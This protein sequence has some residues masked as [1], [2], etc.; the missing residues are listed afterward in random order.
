MVSA[1]C[2]AARSALERRAPGALAA[3]GPV[4]GEALDRFACD[5]LRSLALDTVENA[6]SGHP[7]GPCSSMDMAYLLHRYHL[8]FSSDPRWPDRDRFVLSG[9]HM[10][11]M[12][13]GLLFL[14][15]RL[16]L[17]DLKRFRQLGSPTQ[18]HPVN[19]LC[20]GVETT[21]GPLG[22]GFANG[23]GLALGEWLG[24][25]TFGAELVDHRVWVLATDGDLQEGICREAAQLAGHW[26]LGRLKV[27]F[28]SNRIQLASPTASCWSEDVSAFFRGAGWRVLE[29]DGHDHAALRG[30]LAA[31]AAEEA[32]PSIL[33]AHTRIAQGTKKEGLVETHGAP[34]GAATLEAFKRDQGFPPD[35]FWVPEAVARSL[36]GTRTRGD[37]IQ[38]A[39]RN[40]LAGK[41]SHDAALD[42]RWELL[43]GEGRGEKL[44]ARATKEVRAL[45]FAKPIATRAAAGKAMEVMAQAVPC[46]VGGSA[47]LA[48]STK[49]DGFEKAVGYLPDG[50]P[51]DGS[52]PRGIHFGV[53]EHAMA[54]IANGLALSGGWLPYTGTFLVFSDYLRPALRLGAISHLGVIHV[55]T[56]DS[57]LLGEDGETH[58]P[59]E[60]VESLRLIPGLTVIRPAD[61]YEAAE[62]WLLAIGKALGPDPKPV[63]LVLS[64]QN[65]PILPGGFERAAGVHRGGYVVSGGDGEVP[66]VELVASGSEV[67]LAEAAALLLRAEGHRVKVISMPCRERFEALPEGDRDRVVDPRCRF[68]VVVEA[69]R[70]SGWERVLPGFVTGIGIDRYGQSAPD[71]DLAREYGFTAEAVAG[72]VREVL[73]GR[74]ERLLARV[75][76]DLAYLK[77]RMPAALTGSP[78]ETLGS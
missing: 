12:L 42:E 53:R 77:D 72:R 58:Q 32:Q 59:V 65:L 2:D 23:V 29:C 52:A 28:D 18:G 57:I 10:S 5:V 40:R 13:Y 68:R 35:S 6:N 50:A 11:S 9:G 31:M 33:V 22:Q 8:K 71:S 17:A 15:G 66:D 73:S 25:R 1:L 14:Q 26:K 3:G 4:L 7:G 61:A 45:S 62:A 41:R 20:P 19:V 67:S 54:S 39:W 38:A 60:H 34:L 46:L 30:S 69:G 56:H 76:A 49:T 70:V 51:G 47:D 75:A 74:A 78:V 48:N 44:L 16:G 55:F 24:R 27:L 37:E 64:R 63:A 21:T 43:Y 36:H